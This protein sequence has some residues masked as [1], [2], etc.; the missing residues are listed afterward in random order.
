MV[1]LLAIIKLLQGWELNYYINRIRPH[2]HYPSFIQG[3]RQGD[4]STCRQMSQQKHW[5]TILIVT[6]KWGWVLTIRIMEYTS[7]TH[8]PLYT[9]N[10]AQGW[11][12]VY[13]GPTNCESWAAK[14][15]HQCR[16]FLSNTLCK[17]VQPTL[18]TFRY[19]A[20]ITIKHWYSQLPKQ[21]VW[22]A[23]CVKIVLHV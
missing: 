15:T 7:S 22:G 18:C 21:V 1:P 17:V 3:P 14:L 2:F 6:I 12:V 10:L 13:Y 11:K 9:N 20:M 16:A 5:G 8:P 23:V 4:Y 19:T